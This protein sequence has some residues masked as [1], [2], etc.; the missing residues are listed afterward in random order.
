MDGQLGLN[1]RAQFPDTRK[2]L[3]TGILRAWLSRRRFATVQPSLALGRLPKADAGERE[4]RTRSFS[5]EQNSFSLMNHSILLLQYLQTVRESR[6]V[7]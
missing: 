3:G 1:Q 2:S 4:T 5:P 6:T 7:I